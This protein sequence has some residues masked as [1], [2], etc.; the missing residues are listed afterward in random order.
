[1]R[2]RQR[3]VNALAHWLTRV[4]I[5]QCRRWTRIVALDEGRCVVMDVAELERLRA[6]G[7]VVLT[8]DGCYL[9]LRTQGECQ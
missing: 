9:R 7:R 8:E 1:M 5:K 4:Q 3:L 2:L 6:L